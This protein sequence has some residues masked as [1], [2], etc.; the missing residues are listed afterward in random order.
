MKIVT[1]EGTSRKE[2]WH[3]TNNKTEVTVTSVLLA[4]A[5]LMAW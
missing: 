2:I 5:P 1:G 4:L 3:W